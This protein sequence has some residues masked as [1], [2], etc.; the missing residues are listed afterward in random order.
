ME[1]FCPVIRG[2]GDTSI[3]RI[4]G[5]P[6]TTFP[7]KSPRVRDMVGRR[8][9]RSEIIDFI[10]VSFAEEFFSPRPRPPCPG[11]EAY[12]ESVVGLAEKE[13]IGCVR[14][15]GDLPD[16]G[17]VH[18]GCLATDRVHAL[19]EGRSGE[20]S[21]TSRELWHGAEPQPGD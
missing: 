4:D 20:D 15:F 8:F 6:Q 12:A 21:G 19:D 11:R 18:R 2:L 14:H 16:E 10:C 1:K 17:A 9:R 7:K 5:A 13:V 3:D